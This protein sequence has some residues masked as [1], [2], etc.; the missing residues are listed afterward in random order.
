MPGIYVDEWGCVFN[1]RLAGL[2]GEVREPLLKD[3]KDVRK[4]RVPRERLSV[5][6]GKVNEFCDRT[7]KFVL[8]KTSV[9]PFEQLQL[10]RKPESFF[11]DLAELPDEF[12]V[13]LRRIHAFYREEIEIWASTD[14]DAL[15]FADDWGSQHQLLIS[16]ALW[17]RMFK[18][19]YKDYI[20]IAHKHGKYIFMHTDGFVMDIF[21]DFVELGLDAVNCQLFCM[22]IEELGRRF[23]GKITFWGEIDRQYLLPFGTP[24]EIGE[25]VR[26]VKEALFRNGGVIAQCEFGV[27]ARPENVSIVFEMWEDLGRE[28]IA[29][30]TIK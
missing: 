8:S 11:L 15:V 14:V 25:A 1:N 5:D 27:G 3:W 21:P 6:V 18:P 17:R 30:P 24:E 16:P 9:R 19:L 7:D 23:A 4:I 29:S 28:N 22:D 13:L 2:M 20:E 26:R 12:F 10:I